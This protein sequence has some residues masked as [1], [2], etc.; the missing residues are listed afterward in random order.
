MLVPTFLTLVV[1]RLSLHAR[2]SRSRV[3]LLE[4]DEKRRENALVHAISK[5]EFE[6]EE[7][8]ISMMEDDRNAQLARPI[9]NSVEK[10]DTSN[11]VLTVSEA[12]EIHSSSAANSGKGKAVSKDGQP[13]LSPSQLLMVQS[14]NSLPQMTK[15]KVYIDPTLNSHATIVSRDVKAFEFHKRGWGVLR[16]WADAFVL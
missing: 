11:R 15:Y 2:S 7:A 9:D 13:T 14:L 12:R 3:R 1:V 6:I 4:G 8:V 5:F 16:H 10:D